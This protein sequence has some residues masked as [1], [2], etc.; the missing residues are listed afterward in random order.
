VGLLV[1]NAFA[2]AEHE[3]YAGFMAL[4][5]AC[6]S[7]AVVGH[8]FRHSDAAASRLLAPYYFVVLNLACVVAFWKFL[9]GQKM[10]LWTPRQGK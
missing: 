10:V 5:A 3:L 8:A 4:Q 9:A 6:Y 2:A 7:V 1:F